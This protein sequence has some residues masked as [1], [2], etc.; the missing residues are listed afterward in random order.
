[1]QPLPE[2]PL[3]ASPFLP[4]FIL[5]SVAKLFL[6][7][8]TCRDKPSSEEC[9]TGIPGIACC[10]TNYTKILWLKT[11]PFHLLIFLQFG[12]QLNQHCLFLLQKTS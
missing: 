9:R 12:A 11:Q 3:E 4:P 2:N 1:M 7:N 8:I 10:V 6:E 5:L